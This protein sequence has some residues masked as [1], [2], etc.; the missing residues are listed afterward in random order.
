M[1]RIYT[2]KETV[3]FKYDS[4]N[5]LVVQMNC[6]FILPFYT[7]LF[8]KTVILVLIFIYQLQHNIQG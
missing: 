4:V 5:I 1:Q 7:I 2:E 6:S 8:Y 3:P